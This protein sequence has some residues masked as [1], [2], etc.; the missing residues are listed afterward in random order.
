LAFIFS[1]SGF[2]AFRAILT[3][4]YS[5]FTLLSCYPMFQRALG[6]S[7]RAAEVNLPTICRT[8]WLRDTSV[9]GSLQTKLREEAQC[10]RL[11]RLSDRMMDVDELKETIQ[12]IQCHVSTTE[13]SEEHLTYIDY[14]QFKKLALV[15]ST[16]ARLF[17]NAFTYASLLSSDPYG[18]I[19]LDDLMRYIMRKTWLYQMRIS[20]AQYDVSGCGWLSESDLETYI[21]DLIPT[22]PALASMEQE[23][24]PYYLCVAVK[25]FVFFLD[26]Q[27]AGRVRIMDLIAS[28]LLEELFELR[29]SDASANLTETDGN[30]FS[31][32]FATQLYGQFMNLDSDSNGMLSVEEL[33]NYGSGTLTKEFVMRV[34]QESITTDGE[35]DFRGF[36]DFSLAMEN[37]NDPAAVNYL[38]KIFDIRQRGYLDSFSLNYF[39]RGI[40]RSIEE[41]NYPRVKFEDINAE[42]FDMIRPAVPDQITALDL[43]RSNCAGLF[44]NILSHLEGFLSY[45]NREISNAPLQSECD[46]D[47]HF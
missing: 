19:S 40:Q 38:F 12:T 46:Q 27:R 10:T 6:S 44:F 26:Q 18:R 47:V 32:Y 39:Y 23:F 11:Q 45:E 3:F 1:V 5:V 14:G 43:K 17:F 42:L 29:N 8:P 24:L 9:N 31:Q 35:M 30:R 21:T 16:K 37:N 15:V 41:H 20:L 13:S 33:M 34:F 28:G 4:R 25:N 7:H 36:V 22:M 2:V